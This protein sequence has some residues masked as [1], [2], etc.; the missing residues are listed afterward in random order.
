M[1]TPKH[2]QHKISACQ[3]DIAKLENTERE[4]LFTR[5]VAERY[6]RKSADIMHIYDAVQC[7]WNETLY[8]MFLRTL[9]GVDNKIAMTTLGQRVSYCIL[10]REKHSLRSLE[11][12]LLGGAGL[13]SLYPDDDYTKPLK[14]EFSHLCSKYN[15]VPMSASE[16]QLSPRYIYNHPTLRLTQVASC[17]YHNTFTMS[18]M[19]ECTTADDVYALFAGE[20]SEHWLKNFIPNTPSSLSTQRIGLL[21]SELLGIN[22]VAAMMYAYGSYTHSRDI[23]ARM[24]QLLENI[25]AESNYLTHPW[26]GAG[27]EPT[28]ATVSQALIQLSKEYCSRNRCGECPLTMHLHPSTR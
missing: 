2:R 6:M 1:P 13:L 12:M 5:L 22:L 19:L 21:K 18:Q 7:N 24:F 17:I 16:W 14:E 10:Q 27:V 23:T 9:G 25:P 11:A 28:N 3:H 8:I 15:I 26:Y 4:L 20:M